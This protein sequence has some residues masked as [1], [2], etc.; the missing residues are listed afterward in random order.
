MSPFQVLYRRPPPTLPDFVSSTT[1]TLAL[2]ITL[3]ERA[4]ILHNLKHMLEQ[5]R[6]RMA[7]MANNSRR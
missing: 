3:Q 5:A 6:Y 7:S 2:Y 1:S 4:Q